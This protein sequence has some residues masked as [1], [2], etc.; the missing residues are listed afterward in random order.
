MNFDQSSSVAC[1]RRQN[2]AGTRKAIVSQRRTRWMEIFGRRP[3]DTLSATMRRSSNLLATVYI[4]EAKRFRVMQKLGEP[5]RFGRVKWRYHVNIF[6]F[7][8]FNRHAREHAISEIHSAGWLFAPWPHEL[9][10]IELIERDYSISH[11]SA[12]GGGNY[13]NDGH[14]EYTRRI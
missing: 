1:R 13:K 3:A 9:S 2:N 11:L 7:F 12:F 14:R 4:W 6:S 8:F 5:V 10:L